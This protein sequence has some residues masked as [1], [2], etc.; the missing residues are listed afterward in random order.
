MT[1]I[2]DRFVQRVADLEEKLNA[3]MGAGIGLGRSSFDNGQLQ[4]YTDGQLGG[5]FGTQFDGSNGAVALS[6]PIPPTPR[7]TDKWGPMA[8]GVVGGL[9][10]RWEGF[11][12]GGDL[13]I[14]TLDHK[15]VEVH[16]SGQSTLDGIVADT[17]KS[18][19]TSARGGE[20]LLPLPVSED[21]YYIR[22]RAR[23]TAGKGSAPSTVLGPFY[24][25]KVR[26]EDLG[27]DIGALAGTTVFYGPAEPTGT[28]HLGDL[29]LR[30][31]TGS[32]GTTYETY[33]RVPGTPAGQPDEWVLLADQGAADA[34]AAAIVAQQAADGKAQ[35]FTQPDRPTPDPAAGAKAVWFESDAGNRPWA[36]QGGDWVDLRLGNGAIQPNS[37]V[38][39]NVIATGTVTAA[40]LEAILIL[41]TTIVA[42][43]PAGTHV[44]IRPDG[45]YVYSGDPEDG[46]PN[47]VIRMGTSTNDY[48]GITDSSGML[49]ATIDDSGAF[50][51]RTANF[52]EDIIVAGRSITDLTNA[53]R[54]HTSGY[55]FGGLNDISTEVGLMEISAT[56]KAGRMY[57][58]VAGVAWTRTD[59]T[60]ELVLRVRSGGA[61]GGA[62]VLSSSELTV[63]Q[64]SAT[65][66]NLYSSQTF[67]AFY[68]PPA[69]GTYRL[70]MTA[71]RQGGGLINVSNSPSYAPTVVAID[72]GPYVGTTV[73]SVNRGGAPA[74]PPPTQQVLWEG[75]PSSFVSYRGNGTTRTDLDY[76]RIVQGTD[77]SG[78][79][80]DGYGYMSFALPSITGTVDRVDVYLYAEHWYYNSGGTAIIN[81]IPTG[82]GGPSLTKPKADYKVGGFPKPGGMW[83]T[84]PSDWWVMFKN[85]GANGYPRID[86]ISLGKAFSS[87]LTY[88][89]RFVGSES[90]LRIW[91]TQ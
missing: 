62:P 45:L 4:Q 80:G 84:L 33:R 34:L 36:W 69:D 53:N 51:G 81:I 57:E 75:S 29:W 20:V 64:S 86:S 5:S 39:S 42:G 6:G 14:A 13:V 21:G 35:V 78:F 54:H 76:S 56:M 82:M 40:L 27:F 15:E 88:Y 38:A 10:I 91:Y 12:E 89:G 9:R 70:L 77:P 17:L 37:L 16:V 8:E 55:A 46:V 50:N 73:G 68:I 23:T 74:A 47:E 30:E 90:R 31:L 22:L 52:R 49:V 60:G 44:K 72:H 58:I 85:G 7:W 61:A 3:L 19:I 65:A 59:A 43:D 67:R 28:V 24:P 41:A 11:F 83:V 79:N 1:G 87:D 25:L 48:F 71:A 26:E 18:T 32:D 2:D 63:W 66:V